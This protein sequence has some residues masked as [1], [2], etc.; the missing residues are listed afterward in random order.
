MVDAGCEVG[1]GRFRSNKLS[2]NCCIAI[3]G[4]FIAIQ[5]RIYRD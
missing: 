4:T 3:S 2:M 5:G 1:R